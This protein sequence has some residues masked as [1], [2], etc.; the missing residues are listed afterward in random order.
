MMEE[1]QCVWKWAR[2]YKSSPL[3]ILKCP[4]DCMFVCCSQS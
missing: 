3:Q 4:L 1:G 2:K